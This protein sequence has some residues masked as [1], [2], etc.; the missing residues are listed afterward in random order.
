MRL[1]P[2]VGSDGALRFAGISLLS[3]EG[4][5]FDVEKADIGRARFIGSSFTEAGEE[6]S[7]LA[8]FSPPKDSVRLKSVI[9]ARLP[10]GA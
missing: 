6:L 9:S 2:F 10:S 1:K 8:I 5:E 4:C 7:G 3:G